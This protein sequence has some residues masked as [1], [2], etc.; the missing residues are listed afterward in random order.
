[1][2][3]KAEGLMCCVAAYDERDES[4]R[5]DISSLMEASSFTSRVAR[6][7]WTHSVDWT[8]GET[9]VKGQTAPKA[10]RHLGGSRMTLQGWLG[11]LRCSAA[12]RTESQG[13][14]VEHR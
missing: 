6:L 13:A 1:M 5:R 8:R 3:R 14:G 10:S 4:A 7:W 9:V 2:E 12:A 11:W